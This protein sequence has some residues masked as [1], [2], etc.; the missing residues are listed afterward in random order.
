[1]LQL[2]MIVHGQVQGVGYRYSI[3]SG[4]ENS[5]LDVTGYVRNMADGTVEIIVESDIETLKEIKK[6]VSVGSRNCWVR[7]VH[8][9]VKPIKKREFSNFEIKE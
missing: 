5:N 4:I 3:L 6:I 1:M 8:E 7:E 2:K 9:E